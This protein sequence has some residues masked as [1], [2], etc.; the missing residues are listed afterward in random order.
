[1]VVHFA[2]KPMEVTAVGSLMGTNYH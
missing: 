2:M 1:M